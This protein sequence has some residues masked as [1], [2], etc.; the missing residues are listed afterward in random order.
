[1]ANF[2]PCLAIYG[3]VHGSRWSILSFNRP[4]YIG[5]LCWFNNICSKIDIWGWSWSR[6]P[7]LGHFQPFL[8]TY[9]VWDG[10]GWA[11]S[12]YF[13]V[14]INVALTISALKSISEAGV[15][16]D[17]QFWAI[18]GHFWPRTCSEMVQDEL[19]SFI[20][21]WESILLYKNLS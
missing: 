5:N 2:G 14:G 6:W 21:Y 4:F 9:M 13:L 10:P 19:Q 17:G 11:S 20:L 7:I 3:P 15:D 12:N 1:M 18:S 8:A 16:P